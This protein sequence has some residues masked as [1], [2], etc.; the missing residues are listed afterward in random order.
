MPAPRTA[1]RRA[2]IAVLASGGGSN[3]QALLDHFAGPAAH[4]GD[5]V[6]VGSDRAD[7]GALSRAAKAGAA[8]GVVE[9]P[10][11]GNGLLAQLDRAG[12]DTLVL[13]G[14]LK[15]IPAAVVHA[16]HGKLLNVHPA[17]LPAFGGSGMYGPRIHAAVLEHG[18]TIT[19]VTVHF[20][21]EHF[22]RG[23]I[24]AQWPVPVL[25]GD[26]VA[27]LA[28]RVLRVEHRLFPLCVAAVASDAIV[29]GEDGRVHGHLD[30]P[31]GVAVPAWRFGLV[32]DTEAHDDSFPGDVARLFP[33]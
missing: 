6:W 24:I 19:G 15:L 8:T 26:S 9:H 13:A 17:L 30:V 2:R 7:A 12:A 18:V 4:V 29:L 20:V 31:I 21:N 16:F 23:P 11:D 25:P 33:R 3:L 22:D 1:P 28:A 10:A 32:P 27:N 14:Y 5:I